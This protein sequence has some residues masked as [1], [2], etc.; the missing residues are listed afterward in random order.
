MEIIER[1]S[2]QEKMISAL[3]KKHYCH[4]IVIKK[5]LRSFLKCFKKSLNLQAFLIIGDNGGGG[6]TGK[7]GH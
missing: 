1:P 4:T 3:T 6:S 7:S 5:M 2:L